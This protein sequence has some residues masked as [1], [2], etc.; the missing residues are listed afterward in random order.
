MNYV[1]F[2]TYYNIIHTEKIS[3]SVSVLVFMI[4]ILVSLC[5][6]SARKLQKNRHNLRYT[7]IPD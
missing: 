6:A 3:T 5:V 2:C 1:Y 7:V 4:F